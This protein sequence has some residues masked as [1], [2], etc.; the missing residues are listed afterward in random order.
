MKKQRYQIYYRENGEWLPFRSFEIFGDAHVYCREHLESWA[1]VDWD[2][3][4]VTRFDGWN[5][6]ADEINA[7][8]HGL[9]NPGK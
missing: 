9:L 6:M 2:E 5:L 1:I 8:A 4:F 3:R 7:F